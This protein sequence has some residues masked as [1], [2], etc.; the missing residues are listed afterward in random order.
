MNSTSSSGT[1]TGSANRSSVYPCSIADPARAISRA[2]IPSFTPSFTAIGSVMVDSAI[3]PSKT[4]F[5]RVLQDE[6][7]G[8]PLDDALT[9]IRSRMAAQ[10]A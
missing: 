8:V 9:F 3:E 7:L 10:A 2:D 4:E 1:P 5:R 6:Q